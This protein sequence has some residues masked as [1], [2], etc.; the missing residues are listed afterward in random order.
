MTEERMCGHQ[1]IGDVALHA[2]ELGLLGGVICGT[3]EK[4]VLLPLVAVEPQYHTACPCPS[5][6]YDCFSASYWKS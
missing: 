4:G 1:L 5:P 3:L 2:L 6:S